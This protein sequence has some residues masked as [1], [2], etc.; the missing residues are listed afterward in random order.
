MCAAMALEVHAQ[1]ELVAKAIQVALVGGGGWTLFA[2]LILTW[3]ILR[4]TGVTRMEREMPS[5]RPEYAGYASVS[6]A[7]FPWPPRG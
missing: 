7:L 4:F 1:P 3:S 6:N 2:P 5:R